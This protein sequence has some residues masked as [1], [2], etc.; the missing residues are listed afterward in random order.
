MTRAAAVILAATL[1]ACWPAWAD[2]ARRLRGGVD[3]PWGLVAVGTVGLL[4]WLGRPG[5][6]TRALTRSITALVCALVVAY[7]L[8]W[9]HVPPLV[10]G[11]VAMT[12]V[13]LVVSRVVF[14]RAVHAAVWGLLLLALPVSSA[15][16]FYLGYPIRSATAAVVVPMLRTGGFAVVREGTV[17]RLGEQSIWIDAPCSGVKMLWVGVYLGLTLA[18]VARLGFGRT[19]ALAA[20]AAA[21]VFVGNVV[22]AAGLF[23]LEAGIVRGPHGWHAGVGVVSFA[24]VAGLIALGAR[25]LAGQRTDL[26]EEP[27]PDP[28][29]AADANPWSWPTVIHI[30]VCAAAALLP[31]LLP[32]PAAATPPG[33]VA[34]PGWPAE[35]EG[36]PLVAQPL[37]E[38][39][40][41]FLTDF[42]GRVGKFTDGKRTIILRWTDRPTRMLHL[43]SDCFRG[44][45]FRVTP[46]AAMGTSDGVRYSRFR[47]DRG[48]ERLIV[49]ERIYDPTSGQAWPDAS[50]WYWDAATGRTPGPWW[51]VTVVESNP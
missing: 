50:A 7:A 47:A 1:A 14:G 15:L 26:A 8:T 32:K 25:R 3:E 17:L 37:S 39:E 43:S 51:A 40:Q 16:Q 45:G 18:G 42:P 48:G 12:A 30:V 11:I 35:F 44:A 4:A 29:R 6:R 2:Y 22:R 49:S 5:G 36:R 21:A 38:R 41:V 10:G 13:A 31:L 9:N 24:L 20:W 23:Y 28:Q 19:L 33:Q 46:E 34:F 27:R